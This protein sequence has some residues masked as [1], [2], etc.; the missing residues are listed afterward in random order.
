MNRVTRV[1][2]PRR[3]VLHTGEANTPTGSIPQLRMVDLHRHQGPPTVVMELQHMEGSTDQDRQPPLVGLTGATVRSL[4]E[5][6][7]DILQVITAGN[8]S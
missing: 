7:T 6:I 4:M 8:C 5:G 1:G 2:D 3:Q